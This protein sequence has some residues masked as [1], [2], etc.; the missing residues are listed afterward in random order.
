MCL[1]TC[2]GNT[3]Q[4]KKNVIFQRTTLRTYSLL[5]DLLLRSG[6][7]GSMLCFCSLPITNFLKCRLLFGLGPHL[8]ALQCLA[9]ALHIH[10]GE[11][12][13]LYPNDW[14]GGITAIGRAQGRRGGRPCCRTLP[15]FCLESFS[16][17]E[18][19][20]VG[21]GSATETSQSVKEL[22]EHEAWW[23]TAWGLGPHHSLDPVYSA[24]RGNHLHIL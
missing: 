8:L 3:P 24:Q 15:I 12:G 20:P 7:H 1:C 10:P 13:P 6:L 17:G 16:L 11:G 5:R 4:K 2:I 14:W 19:S 23:G 18:A 22:H 21:Y 9:L